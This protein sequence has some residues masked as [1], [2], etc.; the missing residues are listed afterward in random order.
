MTPGTWLGVLRSMAIYLNPALLRRN[1]ALYRQLLAPGDLV[2]DV[3]AHLGTRARVMRGCGARVVAFEPQPAFAAVLRRTLPRD[4]VL[5]EAA[6]GAAPAQADMAVSRRHPTVSSL[7][8]Q[9]AQEAAGMP[10]FT[11]VRWDARAAV[12]VT[13]LDHMIAAHG[14]PRYVKIDVE[15]FEAE[16]LAGLSQP[17]PLLSVEYLPGLPQVSRDAI[18]RIAALGDYAFNVVH[19]ENADFAWA[20]WCDAAALQ[21]W[22]AAQAPDSGSGDVY[23]RLRG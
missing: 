10:G 21:R 12:S 19:G 18:D 17:V 7:R 20:D 11:H 4:I 22:L 16:V 14:L 2:F 3:G 23:A 6:L 1:R 8:P 13:T 15:G 5:V 9:L